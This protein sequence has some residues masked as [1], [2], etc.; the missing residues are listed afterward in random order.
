MVLDTAFP[1]TTVRNNNSTINN[2]DNK[3]EAKANKQAKKINKEHQKARKRM[4]KKRKT[5]PMQRLS[6]ASSSPQLASPAPPSYLCAACKTH[7]SSED[8]IVSR[9]SLCPC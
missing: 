6:E 7:I 2:N 5:N 1:R 8:L 4:M 3:D 9:V